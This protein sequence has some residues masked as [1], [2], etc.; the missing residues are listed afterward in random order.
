[1]KFRIQ[2]SQSRIPNSDG[3]LRAW[4]AA[5]CALL[6]AA[7]Q[8]QMADQPRHKPLGKS[9]FFA[10]G[11]ASRPPVEGTVARGALRDDEHFFTGAVGG[12]P[13]ERAPLAVTESLL[14]RGR[15]RYEIFCAPCHDRVGNGRGMIVRRGYRAP[16][17][18]HTERLRAAPDGRLFDVMTRGFGQMPAY[19]GQIPPADRWAIVAYIRALQLSQRA[20]LA[21]APAAEQR[22]LAEARP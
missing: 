12:K 21:D 16:P 19:A 22:R 7:C 13:A 1:M 2:N 15:E 9:R 5:A 17:S 10:D 4:R 8:Q 3:R 18:Y 14:R 11:R 20:A 6:L